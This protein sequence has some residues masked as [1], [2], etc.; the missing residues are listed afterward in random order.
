MARGLLLRVGLH[1]GEVSWW[2]RLPARVYAALPIILF[3][4][5]IAPDRWPDD[6]ADARCRY[7]RNGGSWRLEVALG[8]TNAHR[9]I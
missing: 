8:K 3:V 5:S 7:C 6:E 4:M 1:E 9:G 2:E